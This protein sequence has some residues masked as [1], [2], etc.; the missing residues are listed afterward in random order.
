V[1]VRPLVALLLLG[2]SMRPADLGT[3]PE[4]AVRVRDADVL[5]HL[6]PA[7][8]DDLTVAELLRRRPGG[9][10]VAP[11]PSAL[12]EATRERHAALPVVADFVEL[13]VLT[14]NLGLLSRTYLG[15]LV[16]VPEIEA[17]RSAV[18]EALFALGHDI[19][20]LQEV[21]EWEDARRIQRVGERHGYAVWAGTTR[22]HLQHGLVIAVKLEHITGNTLL[23]EAQYR[24]QRKLE[25][26]PGP[27]VKRGWLSMGFDL[28]GTD[29]QLTVVNTHGTSF[30]EY[31]R[32]RDLQARELGRAIAATPGVVVLGGD[33]NSGPYY[34][35]ET[36]TDGIGD[37]SP[38]W[39]DNAVSWGLWQHYGGMI[40][41]LAAAG[42]ADDV[43]LGSTIPDR[44][45]RY[46]DAPY[47]DEGW[48]EANRGRVFT[49]TD[50]N[51]LYFEQYAGTEPPARLDH[52]LLR[53]PERRVRVVGAGLTLTERHA[54]G[55][56]GGAV[57]LSDHY[58][59]RATLR[60][61][62]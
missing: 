1:T 24:A 32:Q 20:L 33:L 43:A 11:D 9:F 41:V 38:A 18:P 12:I 6:A 56:A 7:R 19:L 47:G 8:G 23:G 58:G 10:T 62:R 26:W 21:W 39:W 27:N 57:E 49:G 25:R 35:H 60:V 29:T 28:D 3:I 30:P 13:S 5:A 2:C 14:Y 48:C 53:D 45:Q 46:L 15:N 40:D 54:L 16:E 44:W 42:G 61:A 51:R 50:C 31:W 55:A 34:H 17:R 59:V 36:W 4:D 52:V 37:P 22:K